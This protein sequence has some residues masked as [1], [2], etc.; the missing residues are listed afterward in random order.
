MGSVS[1]PR[2][3]RHAARGPRE[4]T[5]NFPTCGFQLLSHTLKRY[6]FKKKMYFFFA[7]ICILRHLWVLPHILFSQKLHCIQ[8]QCSL[9]G[10]CQLSNLSLDTV[11]PFGTLPVTSPAQSSLLLCVTLTMYLG[12]LSSHELIHNKMDCILLNI[13]E[14][15]C[16]LTRRSLQCQS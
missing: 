4:P 7:G 5:T 8:K 2:I 10:E 3:L 13:L 14:N 9:L 6:R 1:W 15:K 12:Y 11:P 16:D